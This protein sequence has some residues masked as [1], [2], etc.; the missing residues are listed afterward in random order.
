VESSGGRG[1]GRQQP[2]VDRWREVCH[3]VC[4]RQTEEGLAGWPAETAYEFMAFL[5]I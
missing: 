4:G 2:R 5:G 3:R 1:G